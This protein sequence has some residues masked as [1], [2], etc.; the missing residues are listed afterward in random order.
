MHF[1]SSMHDIKTKRDINTMHYTSTSALHTA[2][3][4]T[5]A[6]RMCLQ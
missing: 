3:I 6:V 1:I 5:I 4:L 2:L